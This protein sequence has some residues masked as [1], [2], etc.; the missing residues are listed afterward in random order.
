MLSP[1]LRRVRQPQGLVRR[2]HW[3]WFCALVI[4]SACSGEAS[5]S[6]EEL[7]EELLSAVADSIRAGGRA[8][9]VI[10]APIRSY[11][12]PPPAAAQQTLATML[13]LPFVVARDRRPMCN[14]S[15]TPSASTGMAITV[16]QL[17]V[18]RDSARVSVLRTCRQ[19]PRSGGRPGGFEFEPTW[20]LHR[21]GGR[22]TVAHTRVRIT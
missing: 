9:V 16:T 7:A 10:P 11:Q 14:G 15:D 3:F 4:A 5:P 21:S 17:D 2:M 8:T 19:Q 13:R 18:W 1:E 20:I 22:W 12:R 6:S